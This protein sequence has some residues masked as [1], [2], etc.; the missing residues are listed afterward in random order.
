MN[1]EIHSRKDVN[2]LYDRQILR[3]VGDIFKENI[4]LMKRIMS[5]IFNQ[6]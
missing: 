1:L 5:K 3:P 6:S 4:I 2:I